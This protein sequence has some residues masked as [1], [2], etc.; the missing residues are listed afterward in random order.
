MFLAVDSVGEPIQL[1][2]C[3]KHWLIHRH[4]M[5]VRLAPTLAYIGCTSQCYCATKSPQTKAGTSMYIFTKIP[6][7]LGDTLV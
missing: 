1:L 3:L 4:K 7:E 6:R 2:F 5:P